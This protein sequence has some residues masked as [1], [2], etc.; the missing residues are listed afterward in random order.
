MKLAKPCLNVLLAVAATLVALFAAAGQAAAQE[1]LPPERLPA[2]TT[3]Y[4]IW[5]GA[6]APAV[7]QANSL[8]A[9]WDDPNFAPVRS[10]MASG[11]LP[12]S[13]GAKS[14]PALT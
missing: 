12:G 10:A 1:P 8:L 4:L 5:R 3:F 14:G 2:R 11:L 6:P 7:R 9:L 13:A